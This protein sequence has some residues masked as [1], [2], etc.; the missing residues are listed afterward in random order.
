MARTIIT[1][2]IG[3]GGADLAAGFHLLAEVAGDA[4]E[5]RAQRAGRLA[6]LDQRDVGLVEELGIAGQGGG[7]VFAASTASFRSARTLRSV[8]FVF[9]LDDALQGRGERDARVDHDG[10]LAGDVDDV[11]ACETRRRETAPASPSSSSSSRT[12]KP[13]RRS[14]CVASSR[15]AA[16]T[17]PSWVFPSGSRTRYW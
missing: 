3:H 12:W 1:V 17:V 16:S 6:G 9:L 5:H 13:S 4:F 7:E 15:L 8:G 2:G 11:A 14:C 10:Q